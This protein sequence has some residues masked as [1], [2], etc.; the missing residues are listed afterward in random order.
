MSQTKEV[1]VSAW[2]AF[3]LF[4][5]VFVICD[6]WLYSQGHETMLWTHKTKEEKAIQQRQVETSKDV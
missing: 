1:N 6:T 4:A 3:W 2:A 5:A